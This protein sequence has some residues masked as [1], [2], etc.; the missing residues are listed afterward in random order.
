METNPFI[1]NPPYVASIHPRTR[2]CTS[3][4][5]FVGKIPK[6]TLDAL[7]RGHF[8]G[9]YNKISWSAGDGEIIA[10]YY[11]TNWRKKF[12]IEM[13]NVDQTNVA[14]RAA[15]SFIFHGAGEEI[16]DEELK[17]FFNEGNE[18]PK[19]VKKKYTTTNDF[20]APFMEPI[21]II[22]SNIAVYP[23]DNIEDIKYKYMIATKIGMYRM[24]M[25]YCLDDLTPVYTYSITSNDA[26]VVPD[27]F[28]IY[29]SKTALKI[30]HSLEASKNTI[31]IE[32]YDSFIT[33]VSEFGL[34]R[35]SYYVDLFAAMDGIPHDA[36]DKYIMNNM[37]YGCLIKLYPHLDIDSLI[38]ALTE[39]RRMSI[40]FPRLEPNYKELVEKFKMR[41]E[42][43]EMALSWEDRLAENAKRS[44]IA[45]IAASIRIMPE[46]KTRVNVRNIFDNV[47]LD[48]LI[49]AAYG[50]FDV[51]T[52]GFT[53]DNFAPDVRNG[54]ITA[55]IAYKRHACT[56]QSKHMKS[57]DWFI[58]RK[59]NKN[60]VNF[61]I[62]K[63]VNVA[64]SK[65]L[66]YTLLSIHYDGYIE[67]MG[68]W[69]EDDR[70]DFISASKELI[71][72][73]SPIIS[74]VN[75][76]GPAVF[77]IGSILYSDN[78]TLGDITVVAFWPHRMSPTSFKEL[79]SRLRQFEIAGY[80][81]IHGVQQIGSYS[82]YFSRGVIN[83]YEENVEEDDQSAFTNQYSKYFNDQAM[84][85]W[86]MTY[87][88][89]LIRITHR[90]TDVKVEFIG[91]DNMNEF[92]IIKRYVFS[93]LD[94]LISGPN[95]IKIDKTDTQKNTPVE[96]NQRL[97]RLQE[98][99]PE[100]FDL[101][102][103]DADATVYS[104][105]CQSNRQPTIY[106]DVDLKAMSAKER[107]LLTKYWNFTTKSPAFY[108]CPDKHFPHISFR[109]GQH[110]LG[111]CLPCCKKMA[112][113]VKSK[114][115]TI[116]NK[117]LE[118]PEGTFMAK[119]KQSA[120]ESIFSRHVLAYGKEISVGRISEPPQEVRDSLFLSA[121]PAPYGLYVVG[122][123]QQTPAVTNAGFAF[124]LAH[125]LAEDGEPIENVL[126]SLAELA[127]NMGDTFHSVGGGAAAVFDS[128]DDL[129]YEIINTFV[130][131]SSN[132]SQFG[133]GGAA[134]ES[135]PDILCDLARHAYGVEIVILADYYNNGQITIEASNESVSNI[136]G[137]GASSQR[138][139]PGII[140]LLHNEA[141]TFPL[142]LLNP[143]YYLKYELEDRWQYC[144]RVF[145]YDTTGDAI[146]DGIASIIYD[147]LMLSIDDLQD[148]KSPDLTTMLKFVEKS[149]YKIESRLVDIHNRCY[150]VV[151]IAPNDSKQYIYFPL[152]HS[153]YPLDGTP[154]V[155]DRRAD[156]KYLREP[157]MECVAAF[158][159][160]AKANTERCGEINELKPILLNN[161]K[162]IGFVSDTNPPLYFLH[163]PVEYKEEVDFDKILNFPYNPSEIDQ[164]ILNYMRSE[165][166]AVNDSTLDEVESGELQLK[167]RANMSKL[168][169]NL[170]RL[171][172]AEFSFLVKNEKNVELRN[173]KLYPIFR[174]SKFKSHNDITELKEAL[175][176]LL[177]DFIVDIK[178]IRHII[179][180][181]YKHEDAAELIIEDCEKTKFEFDNILLN[182]LRKLPAKE[183]E[184]LLRER[185]KDSYTTEGEYSP[186][187]ELNIF[188]AC[189]ETTAIKNTQNH[190]SSSKKIIIPKDR[191]N[192][193]IS[194]L[195][196]DI[197]NVSKMGLLSAA[198]SGIFDELKFIKRPQ[199]YLTIKI[200]K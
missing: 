14:P 80:I 155:F 61:A 22:F 105:L 74:M 181:H 103:H 197:R 182:T 123:E 198:T 66:T 9:D 153:P 38:L 140:L 3:V 149:K 180:K 121:I 127:K 8:T 106:D 129:A 90:T 138:E 27:T 193:L 100:L 135:W 156:Y 37:Y 52:S 189:R 28:N 118:N 58:S 65:S 10:K 1:E 62:S 12:R 151:L 6:A 186:D 185:M 81:T 25:F 116:D 86:M 158:N 139:P 29:K 148:I 195:L 84:Y 47:A 192:D 174:K 97:K 78:C 19:T 115:R 144:R 159:K 96:G 126:L 68:D 188:T 82:F 55:V 45:V 146:P 56:F 44:P 171:F 117:C 178:T 54:D 176:D 122:V 75:T 20:T 109:P 93:F 157:L 5:F 125:L 79:K 49:M 162:L 187:T 36:T 7:K 150:G 104:V 134:F 175:S 89:R 147:A 94:S 95:K 17:E 15:K 114:A 32:S 199:E 24:H 107:S 111:Y 87:S 131:R 190:C 16:E 21:P 196:M 165:S 132:F 23:T 46:I 76:M 43:D 42:I 164:E 183:A 98:K 184:A 142:V 113:A 136:T 26:P 154:T 191:I 88:G 64:A 30:D 168:R 41:E 4:V 172:L 108:S 124:S 63:A 59:Y 143:K 51:D 166:T 128:A 33:V 70:K 2:E 53:N 83:Y 91:M 163:D 39:P 57:V 31:R 11:G 92:E 200:G 73:V 71:G 152:R 160:F 130:K 99:D 177:Q 120:E 110:P 18:D 179:L 102:K 119:E 161:K 35:R 72:A 145:D 34:I 137:R 50:R 60:C 48:K 101:K 40:Q 167:R 67:A 77:P 133:H 173:K 112:S 13:P 141:G 85:K 69:K 169:N 194:I 170:Y